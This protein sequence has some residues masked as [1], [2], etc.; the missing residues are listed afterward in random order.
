MRP[1][2][3][4]YGLAGPA[5]LKSALSA[6]QADLPQSTEVRIPRAAPG[7]LAM[8]DPGSVQ[9][10]LAVASGTGAAAIAL[11]GLFKAINTYLETRGGVIKT[12]IG[13]ATLE[14]PA[15]LPA[16]ERVRMYDEFVAKVTQNKK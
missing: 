3:A 14:L 16:A 4:G 5:D 2:R 9:L 1:C 11:K 15:N 8:L 6:R 7:G 10:L 12:R 13:T